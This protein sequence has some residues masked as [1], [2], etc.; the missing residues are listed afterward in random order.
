MSMENDARPVVWLWNWF[1]LYGD[2]WG[3]D[4]LRLCNGAIMGVSIDMCFEFNFET[5]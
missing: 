1:Q 3:L 5:G 4:D 2:L